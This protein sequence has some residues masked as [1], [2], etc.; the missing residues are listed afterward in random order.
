MENAK[1]CTDCGKTKPLSEFSK[2]G[3]YLRS[4]CRQCSN[5]RSKAYGAANRDRR[6]ERLR[7]WRQANPEAAKAKDLR[8]RLTRKYGLTPDEVE[9]LAVAQDHRCLLCGSNR[10]TLVV[11][12]CHETGRVRGLLCRSCNTI[13]GQ[14]ERAPVILERL[15]GYLTHENTTSGLASSSNTSA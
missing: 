13:V 2:S 7:E 3:K 1:R 12:H 5:E 4:Y 8:A 15:S 9:A 14:V 6:N 11:D 10:R